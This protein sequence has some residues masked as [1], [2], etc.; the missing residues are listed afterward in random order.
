VTTGNFLLSLED[1]S[2]YHEEDIFNLIGRPFTAPLE[3]ES[4]VSPGTEAPRYIVKNINFFTTPRNIIRPEINLV[5]FNQC[6]PIRSPPQKMLGTP[7]EFL[8]PEVATGRPASPASDVWA[9][10]CCILRLRAGEGPFSSPFD[11]TCPEDQ[12]SYIIRTLGG[13]L[14]GE[15]QKN[16]LWDQQGWPTKDAK[17]GKLYEQYWDGDERS[18]KRLVYKIWDEPKGSAVET[19]ATRPKRRVFLEY[20]HQP[21]SSQF[22][23]MVWNPKAIKVDGSYLVGYDDEW[24]MKLA[25]LPKIPDH[26]AALLYDL[27]S[28]IFV[29]DPAKR[30]TAE[31]ILKHPWFHIDEQHSS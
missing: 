13:G 28:Q 8:A 21:F 5:D 10:G 3:T 4:G 12:V 15:W 20:E 17:E 23:G 18:L 25:A 11:V 24:K 29:Y 30:P 16:T 31:E 7:L 26:E 1:I 6:F 22:S 14:P 9:L 19:G 27:L 2:S